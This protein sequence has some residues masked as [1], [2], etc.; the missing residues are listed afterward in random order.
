MSE[1]EDE[2]WEENMADNWCSTLNEAFN[3]GKI[4]GDNPR[5]P[6]EP[7]YVLEKLAPKQFKITFAH[8]TS[9]TPTAIAINNYDQGSAD[10]FL[11]SLK[12]AFFRGRK[13]AR[14]LAGLPIYPN[15]TS[16]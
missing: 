1:I 4:A 8:P 9:N 5:T 10:N 7:P 15:N 12:I 14:S 2:A 13:L 16:L 3:I 6:Q 11:T